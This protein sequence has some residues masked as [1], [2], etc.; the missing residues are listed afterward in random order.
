MGEVISSVQRDTTFYTLFGTLVLV[1]NVKINRLLREL[2]DATS[3]GRSK[4]VPGLDCPRV[5]FKFIYE[6]MAKPSVLPI[7]R[8]YSRINN[9]SNSSSI[10]KTTIQQLIHIYFQTSLLWMYNPSYC[11]QSYKRAVIKYGSKQGTYTDA[12]QSIK[13]LIYLYK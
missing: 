10:Y 9:R 1:F 7:L 2:I 11:E 12:K 3:T 13:I 4:C 6:R 8:P 5:W